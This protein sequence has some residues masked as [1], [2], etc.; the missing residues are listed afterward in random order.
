MAAKKTGQ[1]AVVTFA[2]APTG[3]GTTQITEPD[4]DGD[5]FESPTLAL[6]PRDCMPMEPTDLPVPGMLEVEFEAD[7]SLEVEDFILLKQTV[8]LTFPVPAGMTNGG[9]KV[10]ANAFVKSYKPG[11]LSTNGR[12]LSTLSVQ[13]TS[14]P[15]VTAASA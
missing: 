12:R 1:Q 4:Y 7:E 8:T 2:T 14:Y 10:W 15:V 9:T 13:V 3:I 5:S 6:D 11:G